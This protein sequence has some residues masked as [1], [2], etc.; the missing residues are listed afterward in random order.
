M[1]AVKSS[2]KLVAVGSLALLIAAVGCSDSGKD[3]EDGAGGDGNTTAGKSSTAGSSSMG[4]DK[5]DGVGGDK[6]K[7]DGGDP[8]SMPQGGAGA[9]SSGGQGSGGD[10]G[11]IFGEG[12]ADL[13]FGGAGEG[14]SIAKFCNS[15][16]FDHDSD[17]ETPSL[18][19][20]M[21]LKV[22]QGND[23][24]EFEAATGECVP[25]DCQEIP[26]GE[27][28]LV[29]L[30]DKDV[31]DEALDSATATIGNGKHIIFYTDIADG[32]PIWEADAL[33]D[34]DTVSCADIIYDD[35]YPQ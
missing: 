18:D 21:V 6:G 25:V 19:T 8:T 20:V 2:L 16:V 34:P 10:A 27:E 23:K 24:V 1:N 32:S 3:D 31:P 9:V 12:G 17:P 26:T 35:V 28:V 14:P 33:P 15:M 22:G 4:G 5:G 13:G 29:E 11:P 7:G 30:F